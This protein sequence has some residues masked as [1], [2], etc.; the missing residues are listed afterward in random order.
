[1]DFNEIEATYFEFTESDSSRFQEILNILNNMLTDKKLGKVKTRDHD[2][3]LL[4]IRAEDFER[5]FMLLQNR[6]SLHNVQ[7]LISFR[8]IRD[9]ENNPKRTTYKI[10]FGANGEDPSQLN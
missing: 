7:D 5:A 8:L 1:M 2:K 3:A 6:L 4:I 9:K 10:N